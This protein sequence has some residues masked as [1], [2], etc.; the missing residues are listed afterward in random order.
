[1]VEQFFF[2]QNDTSFGPFSAVEMRDLATAE[3]IQPTD[4]VWRAG[5][6][7]KVLAGRVK[8]LFAAPPAQPSEAST[9]EE[10]APPPAPRRAALAVAGRRPEP[11]A[12]PKRVVS[13]KGAVLTGQ[14]GVKVQFRKKCGTCGHEDNCRS[15]SIIR[16]GAFRV[17]FFCPKCRKARSAEFTAVG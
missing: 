17:P 6:E 14:D 5:T 3:R 4:L 7:H 1:M 10:V 2:S 8:N 15:S 11:P 13:V 9:P 12:R 16:L